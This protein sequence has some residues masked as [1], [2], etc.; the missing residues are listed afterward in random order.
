MSDKNI[1]IMYKEYL[2]NKDMFLK[3]YVVNL[4]EPLQFLSILFALVKATDGFKLNKK[5][6]YY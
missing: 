2:K 6:S 3:K 1:M 4:K 5:K